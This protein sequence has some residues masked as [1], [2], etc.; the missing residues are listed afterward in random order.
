LAERLDLD[1]ERPLLLVDRRVVDLERLAVD[2]ERDDDLANAVLDI[3]RVSGQRLHGGVCPSSA[4]E[5]VRRLLLEVPE[6]PGQRRSIGQ[7]VLDRPN[8]SVMEARRDLRRRSDLAFAERV[9]RPE[10]PLEG[11]RAERRCQQL[12]DEAGRGRLDPSGDLR[13]DLARQV[14]LEGVERRARGVLAPD[15]PDLPGAAGRVALVLGQWPVSSVATRSSAF[16]FVEPD[17]G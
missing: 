12:V 16:I 14:A 5:Q 6:M 10:G 11:R 2:I 7:D 8:G 15:C 17:R 3:C 9:D 13:R 1:P 4:P